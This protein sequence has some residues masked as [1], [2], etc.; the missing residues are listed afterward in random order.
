MDDPLVLFLHG[1]PEFWW[2]WR[3]QLPVIAEAGYRAVAMDLRGYGASD[4][5]PRGYDPFTVAAD[6][7]G[8]IRSLGATNAV[9]VG[10]GWGGFV[11]WSAAVLAPRQVRALAAVSAPHPLLLMRSGRPRSVAQVGWFQLPILPERRLLAH[12]GIHIERLLRSWSAPGGQFPDAEA[13]RRYRAALQVWP[14]PHCALEYHRWFV[15]S[16][17]RSDGRRFSARMREPVTVPVL[18]LNGGKDSAL[19]P[20]SAV[21]PP[22]LVTGPLRH[23]VLTSAGH[24]PH[25]ESPAEFSRVL[26]DWL[27]SL[28]S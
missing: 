3:H 14:A 28:P 22:K 24:F 4:K 17:L 1:F 19:A 26:L 10:H 7:S 15:R 8:V 6:V 21:L 13:S 23:E 9:V 18:Q 12:D 20:E 5:T 25:E 2:A 16:R 11:G 27:R